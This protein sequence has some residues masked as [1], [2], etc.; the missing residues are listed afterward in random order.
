MPLPRVVPLDAMCLVLARVRLPDWQE[1]AIDGVIVRAV[2]AGGPAAQPLAEALSKGLFTDRRI[3]SPPAAL[4][5][6]PKPSRPRAA[7]TFFQ[8]VPH[9]VE[10][11]PP[12]T[13]NLIGSG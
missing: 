6:D 2:E 9:L 5:H 12:G 4:K 10:H 7:R 8:I 1:H 11:A 3:P 13:V